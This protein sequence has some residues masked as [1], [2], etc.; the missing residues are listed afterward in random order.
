MRFPRFIRIREDK[1]IDEASTATDLASI[2]KKQIET[3]NAQEMVGEEE[4]DDKKE[5]FKELNEID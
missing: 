5:F 4:D 3:S 2:W 1:G